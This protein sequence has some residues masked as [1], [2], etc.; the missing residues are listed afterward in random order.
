M[1]ELQTIGL[2][3]FLRDKGGL[4]FFLNLAQ[5]V[6]CDCDTVFS[7]LGCASVVCESVDDFRSRLCFKMEIWL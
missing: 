7:P 1:N 3:M 2:F 4:D 5:N 6:E